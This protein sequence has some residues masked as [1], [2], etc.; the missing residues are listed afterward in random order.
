[1]QVGYERLQVAL[2]VSMNAIDQDYPAL[3]HA[4]EGV[5]GVNDLWWRGLIRIIGVEIEFSALRGEERR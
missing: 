3:G 4:G 5:A 1:M 2:A